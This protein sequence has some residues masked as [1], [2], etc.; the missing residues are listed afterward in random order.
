MSIPSRIIASSLARHSTDRDPGLMRGSLNT[1]DSRRLYH[2]ANPSR[3]HIR[4]F[5]LSPL[6]DRKTNR[7]FPKGSWTITVLTRSANRSKP[8]RISVGSAASQM[9][10]PCAPSSLCKLGR[11]INLPPPIPPAMHVDGPRRTRVP[12]QDCSR[13]QDESQSSCLVR[14]LSLDDAAP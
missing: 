8:H 5:S 7:P 3:S 2:R 14:V 12:L 10:H 6:R 4:I 11:P 1:P 9:R 13:E